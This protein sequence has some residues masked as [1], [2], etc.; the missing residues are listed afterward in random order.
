[1]GTCP[2]RTWG[3]FPNQSCRL[4][5]A[6]VSSYTC[7]LHAPS[8][9][10]LSPM[11]PLYSRPPAFRWLSA[12]ALLLTLAACDS[13]DLTGSAPDG[14]ATRGEVTF[15]KADPSSP[16]YGPYGAASAHQA[17]NEFGCTGGIW[18]PK[19][20]RYDEISLKVSLPNKVVEAAGGATYEP[21]F[22]LND[23]ADADR[24]LMGVVC[25]LPDADD[26]K[27]EKAHAKVGRFLAKEVRKL[28]RDL[29]VAEGQTDQA[30]AWASTT[31]AAGVLTSPIAG[32]VLQAR[33]SESCSIQMIAEFYV[34]GIRVRVYDE[35]CSGNGSSSGDD[36]G[37]SGDDGNDGNDGYPSH[38]DTQF[39]PTPECEDS[40]GGDSTPGGG[41][42]YEEAKAANL[43]KIGK[44]AKKL[45]DAGR[46]GENLTDVATWRRIGRE[47]W[48]ELADCTAN[49]GSAFMG[50]ADF[51]ALGDCA[52]SLT[53][54]FRGDDFRSLLKRTDEIPVVGKFLPNAYDELIGA[55]ARNGSWGRRFTETA[56]TRTF[57]DIA[58]LKDIR[59]SGALEANWQV[60]N[61]SAQNAFNTFRARYGGV[62]TLDTPDR[63][64]ARLPGR[65][66]Q[67]DRFITW[68]TRDSTGGP[69]LFFNGRFGDWADTRNKVS[70]DSY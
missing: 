25:T 50:S 40:G 51:F 19:K 8:L 22:A 5:E 43:L 29:D 7:H 14:A 17:G 56:D 70:F 13:G 35:V 44:V 23:P 65:H 53:V 64:V 57:T 28:Q 32:P 36:T 31:D 21:R 18:N 45:I 10:R 12:L 26:P 42:T 46:R 63:K 30:G 38:C 66:G 48:L 62:L 69:G 52:L 55:I 6:G 1:M 59:K 47:E 9:S 16:P 24:L 11:T 27:V 4:R 60:T 3:A 68:Y 39:I 34:N 15:A 49:I 20:G 54:G 61:A 37:G 41:M 2:G 33:S 67:P 58:K